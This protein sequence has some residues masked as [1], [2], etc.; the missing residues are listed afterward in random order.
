MAG[1]FR[2]TA[3]GMRRTAVGVRISEWVEGKRLKVAEFLFREAD[4][5][6]PVSSGNRKCNSPNNPVN[7]V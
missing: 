2:R 4:C 5:I 7:P 1:N 3:Q 6:F